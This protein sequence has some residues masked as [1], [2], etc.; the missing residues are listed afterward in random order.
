[1]SFSALAG[2]VGGAL[3][4]IIATALLSSFQNSVAVS[5]YSVVVLLLTLACVA[6]AR[7]TANVDIDAVEA[8]AV[9]GEHV[10][11]AQPG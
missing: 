3:A 10:V 6:L 9:A 1:M 5:V 4:P 11:A 8:D 2:V 7:E